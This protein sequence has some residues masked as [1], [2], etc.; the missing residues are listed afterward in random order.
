MAYFPTVDQIYR[1]IQQASI[2]YADPSGD[3]EKY[4]ILA[5]KY[6]FCQNVKD[7][8]D[9]LKY[10]DDNNFPQNVTDVDKIL[11]WEFM[12]FGFTL[13]EDLTLQERIDRVL[14]KI[15][16]RTNFTIPD[17]IELVKSVIGSDKTVDIIEWNC[18]GGAWIIDVS[19]LDFDTY[20]GGGSPQ[21]LINFDCSKTAADYGITEDEFQAALTD[22]YT[23]E[24][25]IYNYTLTDLERSYIEKLVSENEPARSQHVITDNYIP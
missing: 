24:I 11:K 14:T 10:I 16:T 22:A 12:E 25:R 8:Y 3:P 17:L 21:S 23:Y 4:Y 2:P 9:Q 19:E 5:A 1:I 13:S 7:A 20:L 15:R 6:A 18:E